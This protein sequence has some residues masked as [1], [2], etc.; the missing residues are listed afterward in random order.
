MYVPA[1]TSDRSASGASP[2]DRAT[3]RPSDA[4]SSKLNDAEVFALSCTDS[5]PLAVVTVCDA[6]LLLAMPP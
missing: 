3:T 1:A 4:T 5:S 6:F 2:F